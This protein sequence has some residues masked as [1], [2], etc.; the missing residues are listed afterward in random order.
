MN[1]RSQESKKNRLE[2]WVS[3][4]YIYIVCVCGCVHDNSYEIYFRSIQCVGWHMIT[5][6]SFQTW[7]KKK[8]REKRNESETKGPVYKDISFWKWKKKTCSN[9]RYLH[10]GKIKEGNNGK[11]LRHLMPYYINVINRRYTGYKVSC[12]NAVLG[13]RCCLCGVTLQH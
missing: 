1:C 10:E 12:S 11:K 13:G 6:V 3:D 9:K 2:I 4:V 7:K 8:K 5:R